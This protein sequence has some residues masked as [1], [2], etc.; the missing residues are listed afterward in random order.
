MSCLSETESVEPEVTKLQ[1]TTEKTNDF[2]NYNNLFLEEK[3]EIFFNEFSQ[4]NREPVNELFSGLFDNSENL[5]ASET[6]P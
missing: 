1:D 6:V 2:F 3:N 5:F 4:E